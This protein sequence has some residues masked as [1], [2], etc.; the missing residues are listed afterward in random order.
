M[1]Q[2]IHTIW[3]SE[4]INHSHND[5]SRPLWVTDIQTWR[6]PSLNFSHGIRHIE[7][8]NSNIQISKAVLLPKRHKILNLI[9]AQVDRHISTQTKDETLDSLSFLTQQRTDPR[10]PSVL[11]RR[12][13]NGKTTKPNPQSLLPLT[14][15]NLMRCPWTQNKKQVEERKINQIKGQQSSVALWN[16]LCKPRKH[17]AG[18]KIFFSGHV[19]L[20]QAY[21]V[22]PQG[23]SGHLSVWVPSL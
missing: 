22:N 5:S 21:Q 14:G 9:W 19:V 1:T 20:Y 18:L 11:L 2:F 23:I 3:T 16:C 6:P 7:N 15:S 4:T 13:P 10:A 8:Q 12:V 17:E